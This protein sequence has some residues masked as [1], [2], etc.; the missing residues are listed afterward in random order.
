M[1]IIFIFSF[2]V[3]FSGCKPL[4]LY[5]EVR[6]YDGKPIKDVLIVNKCSGQPDAETHSDSNGNFFLDQT[7][8]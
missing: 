5:G 3:L 2:I 4:V 8:Q 6:N 1:Q 7:P